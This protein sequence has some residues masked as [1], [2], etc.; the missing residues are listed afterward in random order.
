MIRPFIQI[1]LFFLISTALAEESQMKQ[2][3]I[4]LTFD[5]LPAV[6][7]NFETI[8]GITAGILKVL[9]RHEVPAVGFVNEVK[10]FRYEEEKAAISLLEDWL[11]AGHELGNHT[12]AHKGANR[13]DF[14]EY[15]EEILK[16]EIL[17]RPLAAKYNAPYRYFRHPM[18]RT[19]P[20]HA[21]KDS[22]AS[23]LRQHD[24]IEAPVTMDHDGYIFSLLYY[25]ADQEGDR[26]QMKTI[27]EAYVVYLNE[28]FDYYEALSEEA[29]GRQIPQI[30]LLHSN[31]INRDY[32]WQL[33]LEL[34]NRDYKFI[35]IEEALRDPVYNQ[36]TGVHK[37]GLSWMH[38]WM[39]ARGDSFDPQPQVP[40]WVNDA[41]KA[42]R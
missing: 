9:D 6:R 11:S 37:K 39:L 30:L 29:E 1:L 23:F 8:T 12:Y 26:D 4:A 13:T 21:Y 27:G 24:Y 36:K 17:S 32:L 34:E 7:G 28:V 31:T 22:L 15:R 33:V 40:G 42:G 2:K 20:D 38:R 19:G 16:G 41:V 25:W 18:L 5:D 10:V 3:S 14:G 35:T